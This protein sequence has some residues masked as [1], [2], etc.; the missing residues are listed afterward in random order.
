MTSIFKY[1]LGDR[2]RRVPRGKFGQ[3]GRFKLVPQLHSWNGDFII[4]IFVIIVIIIILILII[5]IIITTITTGAKGD[6]G[7]GDGGLS[8]QES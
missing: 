2:V 3:L 5:I 1:Q 6:N 4:T 8:Q 7:F